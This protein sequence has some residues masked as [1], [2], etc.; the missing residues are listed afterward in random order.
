MFR[1]LPRLSNRLSNARERDR[2]R[3]ARA[4]RRLPGDMGTVRHRVIRLVIAR[5]RLLAG[6]NDARLRCILADL[7]RDHLIHRDAG[8]NNRALADV[9]AGQKAAGLRGVNALTGRRLVEEPVNDVDFL[10]Q[11]LQNGA[12]SC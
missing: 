10:L 8:V 3:S 12:A 7:V 6:Q 4:N 11:R 9:G 5:H 2:L 1:K